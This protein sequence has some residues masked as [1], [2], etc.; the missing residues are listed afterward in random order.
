MQVQPGIARGRAAIWAGHA[1]GVVEARVADLFVSW[2]VRVTVKEE[3]HASRCHT[4]GNVNELNTETLELEI[5]RHRPAIVTVAIAAD[6]AQRTARG[7]E[8]VFNRDA[9]N[10]AEV[11]DFIRIGNGVKDVCR[12]P[13]VSVGNDGDPHD[14]RSVA[15]RSLLNHK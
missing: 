5:E 6:N 7:H 2:D 13:V 9:A 1:A 4:R 8:P 12:K 11:P 3:L 14:A 10:I 15:S